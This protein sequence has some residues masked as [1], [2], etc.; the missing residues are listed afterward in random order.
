MGVVEKVAEF[1]SEITEYRRAL[2]QHPQTKYEE[3][4]AADFV[5][6]RLSEWGVSFEEGI[7]VTGIVATIEG[8]T[9]VSGKALGLRADLDA[10]DICEQSGQ[11][12]TSKHD[13]KMH[14]CGHDGHTAI[15]LGAVRY[16]SEHRDFDGVVHCIFQPAEE[17]GQGAYRMIEEG[18]FE[19]FPC[20]MV[21]G[22]HN[23]P[24]IEAGKF[25]MC[26]G[27]IMAG[28]D[29]FHIEVSGRGGHAAIPQ[30]TR[31]PVVAGAALV[32]ALQAIVSRNIDPL[33]TAVISVTNF[34]AGSGAFNIIPSSMTLSG[35]VR[36]LNADTQKFI[37]QR[38]EQVCRGI[39]EAYDVNV[40]IS[41][42]MICNS[43][44]V[45]SADGIELA[46]KAAALVVGAQNVDTQINPTMAGEDFAA[47]LEKKPGAYIFLG[48]GVRDES[49]PHFYGLHHP[50]YDFNDNVIP[51]GVS[52]F[53][54]LVETYFA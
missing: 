54:R 47:M 13:G 19:R 6:A 21:F 49:S 15:M 48:Q 18:L 33:D 52:Y 11:P 20:D 37:H 31:D 43:A 23:W 30:D 40:D 36:T 44:T 10:L 26:V 12:W 50:K 25:G 9:N 29:E 16:L 51:I 39:S 2:H 38:V 28:V 22:L 7:A 24:A 35:T 3:I 34:N 42:Y 5:K 41:K 32:Q 45:N 4:Y 1:H 27:P 17:G 8:K 53:V 14:A 46:A